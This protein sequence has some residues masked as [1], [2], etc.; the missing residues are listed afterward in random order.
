MQPVSLLSR[1]A[2]SSAQCLVSLVHQIGESTGCAALPFG[3]GAEGHKSLFCDAA[4]RRIRSA[5]CSTSVSDWEEILACQAAWQATR[6]TSATC[7]RHLH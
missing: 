1:V 2:V 6:A 5:F 4:G 7:S 3:P